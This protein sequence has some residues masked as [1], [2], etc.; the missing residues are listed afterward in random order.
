MATGD[1]AA[2]AL[3]RLV[4]SVR[5]LAYDFASLTI[6][7]F[8]DDWKVG[9]DS[10]DEVDDVLE[11]HGKDLSQLLLVASTSLAE[12][13][14]RAVVHEP[15]EDYLEALRLLADCRERIVKYPMDLAYIPRSQV[16]TDKWEV[17][18]NLGAG[19]RLDSG[20]TAVEALQAAMADA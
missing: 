4:D 19:D 16:T 20:R 18:V 13:P 10:G 14:R 9:V 3:E 15:K 2:L 8:D 12:L 1:L 17:N 6:L 5:D 7:M 11:W